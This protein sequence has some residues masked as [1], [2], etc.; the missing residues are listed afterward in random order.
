MMGEKPTSLR[1]ARAGAASAGA[2]VERI[3]R[4]GVRVFECPCT[5]GS[6][7]RQTGIRKSV[8]LGRTSCRPSASC[9]SRPGRLA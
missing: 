6:Q 9:S 3:W 1:G 5:C 8:N 2:R 7:A 4:R